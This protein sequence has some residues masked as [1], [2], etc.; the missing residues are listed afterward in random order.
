MRYFY[1]DALEAAYMAKNYGMEFIN[2]DASP[3]YKNILNP[4]LKEKPVF[5]NTDPGY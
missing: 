3:E 5:D 1:T 2:T 4:K